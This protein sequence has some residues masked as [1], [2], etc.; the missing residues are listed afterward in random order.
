MSNDTAHSSIMAEPFRV[1]SGRFC[2]AVDKTSDGFVWSVGLSDLTLPDD[3]PPII[4]GTA[5]T[6]S[7]ALKEAYDTMAELISLGHEAERRQ[8]PDRTM[9]VDSGV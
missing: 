5:T 2:A 4:K 7:A 9:P 6:M 3:Y 8:E 1:F